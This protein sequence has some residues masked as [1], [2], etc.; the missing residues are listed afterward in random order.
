MRTGGGRRRAR[1]QQQTQRLHQASKA[2]LRRGVDPLSE[3]I[4]KANT[5]RVALDDARC[6]PRR[7][8]LLIHACACARPPHAHFPSPPPPL[9]RRAARA[10]DGSFP[11][12]T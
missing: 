2:L 4:Q 1:E 11:K 6:V 7:C 10:R 12:L 9:K 3:V 8:V 5:V